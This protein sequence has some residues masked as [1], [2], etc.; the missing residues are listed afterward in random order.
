MSTNAPKRFYKDVTLE[1]TEAGLAIALD[2][3]RARTA[4][5]LVLAAPGALA[6]AIAAEW[7]AQGETV[8]FETMPLTRL[9]GFVLDAGENERELFVD[10]IVQYAASDLLCYRAAEPDLAARQ[11]AAFRPFLDRAHAEGM[12]FAV[13][14]GLLPVEQ[15]AAT[16]DAV[17]RRMHPMALG[18]LFPRKL[19][20]EITGS[21]VLA[22][23]ADRDPEAAFIAA[24]LDETVQA[25]K[26]GRDAEA[27][28][29]ERS[30]RFDYDAVLSYLALQSST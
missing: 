13:T 3:R 12:R 11:E 23:Y 8:R 18:E 25:E 5:R 17:R 10:T 16:L 1:E 24:R 2:G 29:R 9:H 20:T 4:G 22:F 6:D 28:V 7:R 19:L 27:E 14:E 30:L 15:P 21:A 26:W